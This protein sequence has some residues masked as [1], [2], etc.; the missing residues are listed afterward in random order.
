MLTAL[1]AQIPFAQRAPEQRAEFVAEVTLAPEGAARIHVFDRVLQADA[2]AREL[3]LEPR[4]C[5]EMAEALSLVLGVLVE[6]GRGAWT[7]APAPPPPEPAPPPPAPPPR[8]QAAATSPSSGETPAI[9]RSQ[10]YLW[11]GPRAGH[12]LQ[13]ATGV[14][15]GLMPSLTLTVTGGWGVRWRNTWPIWLHATGSL[16]E[17]EPAQHTRYRTVYGGLL[18][19]PL[20][21]GWRRLRTRAC[22]SAAIGALWAEGRDYPTKFSKI[23]LL[24]LAGVELAASLRIAG[25]LELLLLPRADVPLERLRFIYR[26]G[27]GSELPL[28]QTHAVVVSI[29]AGLG[30]RFR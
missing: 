19:C 29:F 1:N 25:P 5:Q 24:Y 7:E 30:L 28:H 4:S 11:L 6:A 27:D 22:V 13:A 12:D 15:Y 21:W 23:N 26:R 9:S 2:G 3:Q 10:R 8:S 20:T 18:T 17:L 16:R 14:S